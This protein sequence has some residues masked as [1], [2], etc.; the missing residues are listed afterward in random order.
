LKQWF[1]RVCKHKKNVSLQHDN[2]TP[3][4]LWTSMEVTE[5]R[6]PTTSPHLPYSPD[7]VSL[8]FHLSPEMN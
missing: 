6:N 1:T 3:H 4:T 5:K 7:L 8:D 2:A